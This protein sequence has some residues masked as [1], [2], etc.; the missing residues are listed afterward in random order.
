MWRSMT[1]A[2]GVAL[3]RH[4]DDVLKKARPLGLARLVLVD[5]TKKIDFKDIIALDR[6]SSWLLY[7]SP[8]VP[9]YE[10]DEHANYSLVRRAW[11]LRGM[12]EHKNI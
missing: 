2:D 5:R 6:T 1:P 3:A 11:S 4:T 12:P 10:A 9:T 8:L 7:A